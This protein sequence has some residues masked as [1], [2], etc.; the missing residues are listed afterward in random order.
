[1][2]VKR[3]KGQT[4]W[5]MESGEGAL[6]PKWPLDQTVSLGV[7]IVLNKTEVKWL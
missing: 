1:M 5:E 4:R 7:P 2:V 6:D 3:I